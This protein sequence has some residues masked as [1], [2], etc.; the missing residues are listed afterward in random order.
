MIGA[1]L[2]LGIVIFGL[3]ILFGKG[4]VETFYKFLIWLIVAPI[5]ISIGFN[6]FLWLWCGLPFWSQ[7]L[8]IL[9][10]PFLASALLRAMFPKAKWLQNMQAAIFQILIY[11]VAFPFRLLWRTGR[12]ISQRERR[13]IRL[14]PYRPVIG[15][16]IPLRSERR[17]ANPRENIFE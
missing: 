9:L 8:L 13:T 16:G 7:I 5:L 6:H 12:F 1:I 14:N 3:Q 10:L 15:G 11:I 2:L 17:E 4:K